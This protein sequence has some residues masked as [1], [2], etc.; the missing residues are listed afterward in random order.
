VF[1]QQ[2]HYKKYQF[3]LAEYAKSFD[4]SVI[5]YAL[6]EWHVH[7]FVHDKQDSISEF[8][9]K[10]HGEYAQ[11]FNRIASRVGHVFGERFNNKVVNANVYGIWL[12]RYIHR[13]AVDAKLVQ[14]PIDYPW[15]SFHCYLGREKSTF[16]K[17]DIILQQFGDDKD[18]HWHYM[19]FVLSDNDGPVD[20]SKRTFTLRTG[21]DLIRLVAREMGIDRSI[22]LHPQGTNERK[23][24]HRA[25]R[26]LAAKYGYS[27]AQ[28]ARSLK[29]SRAAVKAILS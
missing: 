13:Q 3:L 10:L 14:S 27:G 25:I 16:L 7:L 26:M 28:I 18:R 2:L 29:L 22:L 11:Y 21:E 5:A 8:I 12:S 6:M 1:K 20:W 24:R 23:I 15:T 17:P 19:E 4:I 9:M